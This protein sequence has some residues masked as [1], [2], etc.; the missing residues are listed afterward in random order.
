MARNKRPPDFDL[1][2]A[3]RRVEFTPARGDIDALVTLVAGADEDA[4]RD[5]T[6]AL[7]RMEGG[8]AERIA[9]SWPRGDAS[10][11]ARLA[12]FVARLPRADARPLLLALLPSTDARV[13]RAGASAL[14]RLATEDEPD[15][16]VERA[17]LDAWPGGDAAERR[18]LAEALGKVGGEEAARVL[19]TVDPGDDAEL[20]R[21]VDKARLMRLR[22]ASRADVVALDASASLGEPVMIELRCRDGLEALLF[23]E[24]RAIA[25]V[26]DARIVTRGLVTAEL[27]GAPVTLEAARI[28]VDYA[29]VLPTVPS[30]REPVQAVV[31]ALTGPLATKLL[32]T[33]TR[34]TPRLR[35]D[36][37]GKG[38]QRALT[39][40]IASALAERGVVNDSREA[41]WEAR[42][43]TTSRGAI[44]IALVPRGFVDGRFAWRSADVPA[45]SHPTI[46]AAIARFAG[47][48]PDDVVWDPFTGS[49]AELIECAQLGP[50]RAAFGTDIE[51]SALAAA[52]TNF[53]AAKCDAT[54]A[55]ADATTFVPPLPPT[56]I[57]SNPPMGRRVHRGD[58][59]PLL[60]RFLDHLAKV[61]APSAHL[62][63]ISAI[64]KTTTPRAMA[65][66]FHLDRALELDMGGFPGRLE[67]WLLP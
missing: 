2:D 48:M 59:G 41:P 38:P 44:R 12:R 5:A 54:L 9:A 61:A 16:E 64:P 66:G 35:I 43:R 55:L 23:D 32:A 51:E 53:A 13:R 39:W 34:G 28:F 31:E 18:A 47:V 22:D 52:R 15:A 63:W 33:F 57:V 17:L 49:G 45:A 67:R 10:E 25:T 1:R 7:L 56:L 20:R 11:T 46:A 8:V 42:I 60:E 40:R 6:R 30:D 29:F 3:I 19:A 62:V 24:L 50:H 27:R 37:E 4:A 36:W 21:I 26:R 58:V 65:L 14:G